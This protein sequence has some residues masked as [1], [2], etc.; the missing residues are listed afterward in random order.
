MSKSLE[1]AR[2]RRA[3]KGNDETRSFEVSTTRP[4]T[5]GFF[6]FSYTYT[7]LYPQGGRT[8]VKARQTRLHEGK[9]STEA[10]EGE[11]G[12]NVYEAAVR[13]AQQQLLA[14]AAWLLRPLS[15][16]PWP[17]LPTRRD[18]E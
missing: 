4:D 6:S 14:Q 16:L 9:L 1:E 12:A 17:L 10:F 5:S 2:P 11:L 15:W 3:V 13:Q 18:E 8:R 7:E